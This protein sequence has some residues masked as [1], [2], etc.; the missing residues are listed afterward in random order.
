M[1]VKLIKINRKDFAA[2]I[3]RLEACMEHE[4][5]YLDSRLS[6]KDMIRQLNTNRTSLSLLINQTYGMNFNRFIN[7]YRLTELEELQNDPSNAGVSQLELVIKA[8]FSDR[9]GYIRA[10]QR[11]E[12]L[13]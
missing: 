10:K 12:A 9:R 7:R 8:G 5:P 13:K 4:K 6:I 3:R 2:D 1:S 11:E